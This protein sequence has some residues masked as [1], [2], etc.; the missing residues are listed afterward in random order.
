MAASKIVWKAFALTSG[1][2]AAK[3]TR[4]VLDKGWKKGVGGEPPRNAAA[5]GTDWKQAFAFAAASGTA[6]ALSK[7]V[8]TTGAAKAW[9]KTTGS[10]PPGVRE[11]GA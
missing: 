6:L 5:P 2:V 11:A 4:V 3:A 8:A 10:L 9:E 7:A 1:L